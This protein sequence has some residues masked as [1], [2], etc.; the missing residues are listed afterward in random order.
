MPGHLG[1]LLRV[2]ARS[3]V[4]CYYSQL[5]ITDGQRIPSQGS[6]LLCANHPNSLLDPVV[7]GA[8]TRRPVR[9]FA[10]APLFKNPVLGPVMESLDMIPAYRGSDDRRQVRRNLESLERGIAAL[11]QDTAVGIFPEGKSHDEVGVEMVRG[12]AA[13]MALQAFDQGA[14]NL[15]VVPIG[16]NYEWK[17]RFR[18]A[19]WVRVGE[20]IVVRDWLQQHAVDG[21]TG[22]QTLR[23]FTQELQQ[24]LQQ[25]TIHLHDQQ[26]QEWLADL[27]HLAPQIPPSVPTKVAQ[28]RRRKQI[29]DAM[30][31]YLD[32]DPQRAL[33]VAGKIEDFRQ[34][35]RD[36]GLTPG[37]M[38]LRSGRVAAWAKLLGQLAALVVTAVPAIL[39]LV[40]H[41]LPYWISR[42]LAR[43]FTPPGRTAVSFY[44]VLVG[45]PAFVI[46]YLLALWAMLWQLPPV[47]A[48]L[49][50]L[51]MP[52]LGLCALHYCRFARRAWANLWHQFRA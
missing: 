36:V 40:F 25:V 16:L 35:A 37:A 21:D 1:Q 45:C 3:L 11:R 19:V 23:K 47:P 22:R 41:A 26:W 29:A 42:G 46:W 28:L 31:Y 38:V 2:F 34:Q 27:E 15:Q 12:G 4:R 43:C 10:K 51:A 48:V 9:F 18:S 5:E 49:L 44:R 14:R 50:W 8:A 6:V 32:H 30:N 20:P 13:R 7:V 33:E 24:R 39:G 52:G 17:E